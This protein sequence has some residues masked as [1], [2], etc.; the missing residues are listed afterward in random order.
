MASVGKATAKI[1]EL[2]NG[3]IFVDE[4]GIE[5]VIKHKTSNAI[6]P[7]PHVSHTLTAYPTEAGKQTEKYKEI[8]RILKDDWSTD[9]MSLDSLLD[10]V[11]QLG[12]LKEYRQ[13]LA[14]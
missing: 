8:R 3:K 2:L 9:L 14:L 11:E 5:C 1:Y 10:I 12:L 4:D 7:Y 13:C 6:F